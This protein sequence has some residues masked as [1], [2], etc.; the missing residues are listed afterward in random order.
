VTTPPQSPSPLGRRKPQAASTSSQNAGQNAGQNA[1]QSPGQTIN[2]PSGPLARLLTRLSHIAPG[3]VITVEGVQYRERR[4]RPVRSALSVPEPGV[5]EFEV[6]FTDTDARK[7]PFRV[8]AT[9]T[10]IYD[11]LVPDP[12]AELVHALDDIIKPGDRVLEIGCG[13]GAASNHLAYL[14][15]PSGGVVALDRDGESIRFARQRYPA[16]QLGFELGWTETLSGELDDAFDAV[17]AA[18]PFRNDAG[19]TERLR[20]LDEI[21]R[22]LRPGGRLLCLGSSDES[23]ERARRTLYEHTLDP[24]GPPARAAGWRATLWVTPAP[25]PM[26]QRP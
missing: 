23:A 3:R 15:G 22:V 12:R 8:R 18:D 21:V 2:Q 4:P 13:T 7:R 25:P 14:V 6:R 17:V 20:T 10:R 9:P 5:R 26:Q 16:P 1:D 19:Q 24:I 11:D